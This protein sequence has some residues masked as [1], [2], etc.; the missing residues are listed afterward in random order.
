LSE[1]LEKV[2]GVG[3]PTGAHTRHSDPRQL[4]L[5]AATRLESQVQLVARLADDAQA[6]PEVDLLTTPQWLNVRAVLFAALEPFPA[7]RLAVAGALASLAAGTPR[8]LPAA[9]EAR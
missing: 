8:A 9:R 5:R 1:L 7:A 3:R 2:R 6:A 4:L